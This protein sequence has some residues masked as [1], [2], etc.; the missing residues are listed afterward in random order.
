MQDMAAGGIA[1]ST[2][3]LPEARAMID[4]K[5]VKALAVMADKRVSIFPD[6]PTL[7][8]LGLN[9]SFGVWRGVMAPK[10][11]PDNVVAILEKSVEKAYKNPK[12]K[13]FMDKSGL[14]MMWKPAAE[15]DK[16]MAAEDAS[17]QKIMKASGMIQ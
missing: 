8:E 5:K 14:G 3:S 12:Y 2:C 15:F 4:A 9:W 13:E 16:F 11:T 6:V 1:V 7:K 17:N 10:G